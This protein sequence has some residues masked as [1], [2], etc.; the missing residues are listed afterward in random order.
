LRCAVKNFET[1]LETVKR[2]YPVVLDYWEWQY[3]AQNPKYGDRSKASRK[4]LELLQILKARAAK[5]AVQY[6]EEYIKH[7]HLEDKKK[8]KAQQVSSGIYDP[9]IFKAVF[10]AGGP[11]SGKSFIARKTT[12]GH[13][14]KLVNSDAMFELLMA[15]AGM[16]LDM[17]NMSEED[18][19][20]K[21]VIRDKAK[22]LTEKQKQAYL[23]GRVG[24]VIDGTGRDFNKIKDQRD[25]LVRLGYDTFMIFV[26]TSQEVALERNR[27]R[28]RS[29][30]EEM[31][32]RYWHDV[33]ANIGKFQAL[34]G[35]NNFRVIDNNVLM[36]DDLLFSSMWKE[37]MKFAKQPIQNPRARAWITTELLKKE[38]HK[39][40][41]KAEQWGEEHPYPMPTKQTFNTYLINTVE[42]LDKYETLWQKKLADAGYVLGRCLGEGE[43]GIAYTLKGNPQIL[44][45]TVDQAEAQTSA[46][47]IGKK[48]KN[49]AT[50]FKV[51]R[52][53]S[54]QGAYFILQEK[55]A[56]PSKFEVSVVQR[57][58]YF[59]WNKKRVHTTDIPIIEAAYACYKAKGAEACISEPELLEFFQSVEPHA[60]KY[61]LACG[62]LIL[63]LSSTSFEQV[64]DLFS[65][66][67]TYKVLDQALS[68]LKQ[69]H[70]VG[71]FFRDSH[72]GNIRKGQELK[73]IDL[74]YKSKGQGK[75]K[76][77]VVKAK[78]IMLIY[79]L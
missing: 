79:L 49:V 54:F 61:P 46:Q 19:Q 30:P 75:G 18:L 35:R 65:I 71:I 1:I 40:G 45:V 2:K 68:G 34:F 55:L 25:E 27:R 10:L 43:H 3:K 22:E 15:K 67:Q 44:K 69:L 20:R 8:L 37:V 53:T 64:A 21:D 76:I 5:V 32:L 63:S 11:G 73:W 36:S 38:T 52:F 17:I 74:G 31:C 56:L 24:M 14:F 39:A 62:F 59:G 41:I 72:A 33:Q 78:K 26:N 42:D 29:I 7:K 66:K 23:N 16:D 60:S 9:G 57:G 58:F 12:L 13:G 77:E 28:K 51:F 4:A 47:L 48:L 6:E 70:E 50:I